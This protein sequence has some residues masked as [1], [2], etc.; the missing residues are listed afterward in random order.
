MNTKKILLLIAATLCCMLPAQHAVSAPLLPPLNSV[1]TGKAIPGKFIWFELA[2]VDVDTQKKFYSAVFG[3]KFRTINPVD[4]EYTI[5]VNGERPI[6][7]MFT[8]QPM[9]GTKAGARWIGL[10]SVPDPRQAVAAAKRA[11]GTVQSELANAPNRGSH[12]LLRDP[13]GA[14]FG[15]LKSD[16]GDPPDTTV[17][18]GD[19]LWM[20]LFVPDQ[21][22]AV[23]FYQQLVPYEIETRD[24]E[25]GAKRILLESAN[26]YRAGILPLPKDVTHAGW[27][28]YVRV[29]DLAATI[30]KVTD[31][32]GHILVDPDEALLHG[33]LAI[34]ADPQ[35]G[36]LGIVKWDRPAVAKEGAAQ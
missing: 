12:A 14:L 23:K 31:A 4:D 3:W 16:S 21:E 22:T 2:S 17:N 30:K 29:T 19:F 24:T 9:E 13:A 1:N 34:F 10:M 25:Y 35:G 11:G 20:D 26:H 15:V 33:N 36:V 27:L 28:P 32:G 5:I 18:A 7:G 6:A 8:I